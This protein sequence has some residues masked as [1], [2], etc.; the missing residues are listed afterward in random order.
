MTWYYDHLL[1]Q[2]VDINYPYDPIWIFV[3]ILLILLFFKDL[4][5]KR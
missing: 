5:L 4:F 1:K 3:L 2:R